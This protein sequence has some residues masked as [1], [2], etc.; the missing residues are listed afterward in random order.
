MNAPNAELASV[1]AHLPAERRL[2]ERASAGALSFSPLLGEGSLELASFT[3][4]VR[5]GAVAREPPEP[6]VH[7]IDI[8]N[9][10]AR[11]VLLFEGEELQ[12]AE[13]DRVFDGRFLVPAAPGP[14]AASSRSAGPGLGIG[15]RTCATELLRMTVI[16]LD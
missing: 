1:A 12:G 6:S 4:D 14:S 3:E 15:T 10:T 13:Q 16:P 8:D 5:G 7:D 2:L 9:P 11:S